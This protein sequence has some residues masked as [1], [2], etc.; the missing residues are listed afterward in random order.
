MEAIINAIQTKLVQTP[1]LKY[2][3]ENWG[4]LDY[5]STHP[6]VQF[7]CCLIDIQNGTYSDIGMD[8]HAVPMNRQMGLFNVE[9]RVSDIKLTNGSAKAPTN[10]KHQSRSIFTLIQEIHELIH[11]FEPT[12]MCGKLLRRSINK[13]QRDDGIREYSIIYSGDVQDV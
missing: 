3:D 6:P 9:L 11:G 2:I 7:P 13:V 1:G 4:Q 5:Y 12:P 8:K 10:Q